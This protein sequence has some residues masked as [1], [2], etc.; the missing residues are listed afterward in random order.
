ME[1]NE[2][3]HARCH[4]LVWYDDEPNMGSFTRGMANALA[5]RFPTPLYIRTASSDAFT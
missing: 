2:Y 3:Q 4:A 1:L 5:I